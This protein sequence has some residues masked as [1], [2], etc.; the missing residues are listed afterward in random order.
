MKKLQQKKMKWIARIGA[1]IL[2]LLPYGI[3]AESSAGYAVQPILPDTQI[4]GITGYYDLL[5]KPKQEQTLEMRVYNRGDYD[6]TVSIQANTAFTNANGV[7]EYSERVMQRDPS[8]EFDFANLVSVEEPTMLVPANGSAI[9]PLIIQMPQE[10][11]MG[12]MLGGILVSKVQDVQVADENT[13]K[14]SGARNEFAYVVAVRI[15]EEETKIEPTFEFI[16]AKMDDI[17]GYPA[18][19]LEIRN[20]QPKL[21]SKLTMKVSVVNQKNGQEVLSFANEISMAPNTTMPFMK[22]LSDTSKQLVPGTYDVHVFLTYQGETW[23][24]QNELLVAP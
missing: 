6:I 21:F 19:V 3:L 17:I 2:C 14:Q 9:A 15:R 5:L 20:K 24:Q 4:D 11:I 8:M 10:P 23:H 13:D 1:G 12:E 16:A 7:I 22:V 18:L